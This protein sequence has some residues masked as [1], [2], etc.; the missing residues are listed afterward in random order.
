MEVAEAAV[1]I[2]LDDQPTYWHLPPGRTATSI[3]A[4]RASA[5][6]IPTAATGGTVTPFARCR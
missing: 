2:D 1:V 3:P 5:S 4:S 6:S